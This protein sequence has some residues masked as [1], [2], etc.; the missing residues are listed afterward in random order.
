MEKCVPKVTRQV[1]LEVRAGVGEWGDFKVVWRDR[2]SL[3]PKRWSPF[4]QGHVLG[5]SRVREKSP[6]MAG[7]Q[8]K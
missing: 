2:T 6:A 7:K 3:V 1:G 8:E 4:P 5:H